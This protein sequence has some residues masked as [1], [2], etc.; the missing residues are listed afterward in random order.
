MVPLPFAASAFCFG[1]VPKA[2]RSGYLIYK[3]STLRNVRSALAVRFATAVPWSL[4]RP[5]LPVRNSK[6]LLLLR[7]SRD[8]LFIYHRPVSVRL[9]HM[10]ALPAKLREVDTNDANTVKR[11]L[12]ILIPDLL[13][14]G[15][16]LVHQQM[17]C[18]HHLF[19][20][21]MDM[22][23]TPQDDALI[24]CGEVA[25]QQM[26]ASNDAERHSKACNLC[27]SGAQWM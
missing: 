4:F 12:A 5:L 26:H 19:G 7:N 2:G 13:E 11:L 16:Q 20:R 3:V 27:P 25:W 14:V 23:L 22:R 1:S 17:Q 21:E 6:S 24:L 8:L 18:T 15:R 9:C 10:L